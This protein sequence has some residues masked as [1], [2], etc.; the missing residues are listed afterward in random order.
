MSK[1]RFEKNIIRLYAKYT[2]EE[3]YNMLLESLPKYIKLV[4]SEEIAKEILKQYNLTLY[5]DS[6][7]ERFKWNHTKLIICA[8]LRGIEIPEFD[9]EVTIDDIIER[10]TENKYEDICTIDEYC[11][12]WDG[13]CGDN[14]WGI[15]EIINSDEYD[16]ADIRMIEIANYY[17]K[18]INDTK[19]LVL[20]K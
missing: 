17:N 12:K 8:K 14:V 19:K 4:K 18:I 6:G 9:V 16:G 15:E 13:Y 2:D 11:Y 1:K 20:K 5:T 7:N 10:I 3:I